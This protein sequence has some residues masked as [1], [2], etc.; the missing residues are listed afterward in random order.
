MTFFQ[1]TKDKTKAWEITE[2]VNAFCSIKGYPYHRDTFFSPLVV[3]EAL[4]RPIEHFN[5]DPAAWWSG[6]LVDYL[7]RLRPE[8]ATDL[9]EYKTALGFKHPIVGFV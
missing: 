5:G 2:D 8:M 4:K 9:E 3:P 7:L 6:Q 1:G